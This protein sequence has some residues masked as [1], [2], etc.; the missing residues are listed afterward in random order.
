MTELKTIQDVKDHAGDLET[1]NPQRGAMYLRAAEKIEEGLALLSQL[2]HRF[3]V[4]P[5]EL[6]LSAS[7]TDPK[8]GQP[9]VLLGPEEPEAGASTALPQQRLSPL[10]PSLGHP[11]SESAKTALEADGAT[12]F[13]LPAP[14]A[15]AP[16]GDEPPPPPPAGA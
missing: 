2:G 6:V 1:F 7:A 12:L 3:G 14:L 5:Y 4:L 16:V 13:D 8:T 10:D 9:Q 15:P 11:E